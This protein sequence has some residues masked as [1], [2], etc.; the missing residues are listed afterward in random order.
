[1]SALP[2]EERQAGS[3]QSGFYVKSSQKQNKNKNKKKK[4]FVVMYLNMLLFTK[5]PKQTCVNNSGCLKMQKRE[6]R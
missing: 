4:K 3:C 2:K 5:W 1:M 6:L